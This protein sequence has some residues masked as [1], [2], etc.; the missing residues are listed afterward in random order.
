MRLVKLI[1]TLTTFSLCVLSTHSSL[2]ISQATTM[3]QSIS[4][5]PA[6]TAC[7][8]NDDW[9]EPTYAR[10]IYGNTWYVG[11]CAISVVLIATP[12]G[13]ILID[14]AT[15]NA[16]TSIEM[17]IK[18][19]GLRL[20]D[21]KTILVTHEHHDH[22]GG[23]AQLQK[24]SGAVVLTRKAAVELLQQGKTHQLDPQF[25][26]LEP[27]TPI[28]NVKEI[29]DGGVLTLGGTKIHNIPMTGHTLGGSGWTWEEC[30]NKVCKNIV[31]SDSISAI[32]DKVY[33][34]SRPDSIANDL[35]ASMERLSN[36]PCDIL[37]TGH[38]KQS[39][40]LKRLDGE[41]PLSNP[42]D[43]KNLAISGQKGL[44][45]RLSE[46]AISTK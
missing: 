26:V 11:T 45:K 38:G 25:E 17:N 13:H 37:I 22:I 12:Q 31:F 15:A 23:V 6:R 40:L 35:R 14:G 3:P 4:S 9:S 7:K 34:F 5:N 8:S 1:S 18:S 46:E 29:A 27:F 41:L 2:A 33:R 19:L 36:A 20:S 30:E 24:N 39:D 10:H 44:L 21:I 32:S 28:A 42:Q 43:C 16:A